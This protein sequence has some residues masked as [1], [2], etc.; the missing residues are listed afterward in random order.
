MPD[1]RIPAAF[2]ALLL[3]CSGCAATRPATPPEA[4]SARA[5]AFFERAF[6]ERLALEPEFAAQLGAE[7]RPGDWNDVTED[8]DRAR[9]DLALRQLSELRAS[10]DPVR[11]DPATRLSYDLLVRDLERRVE[12]WRWRNHRNVFSQMGG[13]QSSVPAFL[14]STHR[15]RSE[16]DAEAYVERLRKAGPLLEAGVARAERAAGRGVLA[17]R[18]VFPLVVSDAA[19][20][21]RGR[22]F[23]E[24][25]GDSPLLADFT[26]KLDSLDLPPKRRAALLGD[27]TRALA[28]S[29]GPAY[30]A[31]I[32][33][34]RSAESRAGTDDGAWR[35]PHGEAYYDYLLRQYTTTDLDAEAIHEMGLREVARIHGEMRA[36]MQS[37]GFEGELPDFF[38]FLREDERFYYPDSAE[39]R[40]AYLAE[41]TRVVD[42]MRGRLPEL[43]AILP[44]AG[45]VVRAVEPFRERTAGKAF[46]QRPSAD[47][48]RPGVYYVNLYNMREMPKF[49]L[50]ALAYHEG[51]PGHHMQVAIAGE[52][53]GLPRFRRF[54]GYTA[55]SEGWGLYSERLPKETG[56]YAD[57]YSD[58]GRLALELLRAVRLVVDTGL[59]AK[60]WTREQ[61]VRYHLDNTAMSEDAAVRATDRYIVVPGQATAYTV[62][63]LRILELRDRAAKA[64]GARFDLR[65]FHDV[66][67]SNGPVPLDI[68][69]AEVDRWIAAVMAGD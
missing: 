9:R 17:P 42:A 12:A 26:A 18:F 52:L 66:V 43:F 20:V 54:G 5:R 56:F 29:V 16:Q 8:G 60:R 57:P 47:G 61:V 59:H 40:A 34:A 68:L 50:E 37:V 63:L 62:G 69:E 28:E 1:L 30:R 65:A 10:I 13:L 3:A 6:D 36:I 35:L 7:T 15:V 39:G 23:D 11:L 2:A 45:M 21:I 48:S 67:L 51:V 64:L 55:Y 24:G 58:F 49:E 27:A 53:D 32:D 22:P 14:I 41:A 33:W 19:N 25:P 46:Y 44:R 38:R 31:V 4:E